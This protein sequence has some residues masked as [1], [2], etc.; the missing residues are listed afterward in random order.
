MPVADLHPT[1]GAWVR[2][3]DQ[4]DRIGRVVALHPADHPTHAD[5]DWGVGNADRISLDNLGS[6]LLPNFVV[7]DEP[8]TSARMSLGPG[9]IW[10]TRQIA[11]CDQALVHF[12]RDG[13]LLWLPYETL[14]RIKDPALEYLRAEM[15]HSDAGERWALKLMAHA[16]RTWNEATGALDRLDV[17]P[18]PHQIQLVHKILMSGHS[19]W[20][21][22]DDVGLGK[23]IEVGLLLAAL[24]RQ[25]RARRVLIITPA[26]LTRQWQTEMRTK[27]DRVY[28]IYG[29]DFF[30]DETWKW[31][32]HDRVIASLDLA[33]PRRTSDE[34]NSLDT[35]FGKL[36]AS[37][38]WDLIIF[39]EAHRLSRSDDGRQT[40]RYKLAKALRNRT[41]G[42]LLLT[43]TPHQGDTGKF[44][45]L[46]N[47]A[48]PDLHQAI[49][50]I[51]FQ[52]DIVRD[53]IVRNRK[54]DVTDLEG[55]FIFKG[56]EVRLLQ[57]ES[58]A[59]AMQLD[60]DLQKYLRASFRAAMNLDGTRARAVG[61]VMTIF[62]KLAS[63]SPA[64]LRG[65]LVRR[66]HR[67]SSATIDAAPQASRKDVEAQYGLELDTDDID[68]AVDNEAQSFFA[69][70]ALEL[71]K[72]IADCDRV[73]SD[74]WKL[75]DALALVHTITGSGEKV[76]LF[77]EYRGTQDYLTQALEGRL[78]LTV[79]QIN[80]SQSIDEKL[81]SVASFEGD[82]PV[83]ISTE[84]G[85]EG[86]NLHRNCRYLLN[87]D[88][89]WNP[90]RLVQRIGR[91]YRYGQTRTVRVFNLLSEDTIDDKVL[92]VA[93]QRVSAIVSE[94]APVDAGEFNDRLRAEILGDILDHLDLSEFLGADLD[95]DRS[96]Q[97]I[98][99]AIRRAQ[100]AR[101]LE[102]EVLKQ[103][104]QFDR[105]GFARL[106]SFTTGHL[107][108]LVR[109]AAPRIEV[110]VE[111]FENPER[112]TLRLPETLRGRFPEFAGRLVI[113]TTTSRSLS[114]SSSSLVLLD[115]QNS[116][117]RYLVSTVIAP[118]FGGGF[119]PV[120]HDILEGD[121]LVAFLCRWQNEQ[122]E[123][124]DHEVVF[125]RRNGTGEISIDP[126][127]VHSLFE[128][129]V[130]TAAL[131]LD[132]A[133]HRIDT[134][135]AMRDRIETAV[136]QSVT[137]FRHVNDLHL[138]GVGEAGPGGS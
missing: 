38:S 86:F 46:L 88:L 60:M 84:A 72:L 34:G 64:A 12:E 57:I 138:I 103:A 36:L 125:A 118:E 26:G 119:A 52:P 81:D 43:G 5:I 93:M 37:D 62:R 91:L 120:P 49:M 31:K 112:F 29:S 30:V 35:H 21:I 55:E 78:G 69:D 10:A 102:K 117:V 11:G 121:Q 109:R 123:L 17:D 82:T 96:E 1:I 50:D 114:A 59:A 20:V 101:G 14:A 33:K 54:I 133:Q 68:E 124:L 42:L 48:R 130:P 85:G 65:A 106:G 16:L 115:F 53:I 18:L 56:H 7:Q 94:M 24:E 104:S 22:A 126:T 61:F 131:R 76:I 107:A 73:L 44:R 90:A 135:E 47:L 113:E 66:R 51:E 128:A 70:E 67:L 41:D 9:R 80:G 116:F 111:M 6:G 105:E 8:L 75:R 122:A 98:E 136:A 63:S 108:A 2:Q 3:L 74:D 23:T 129:E 27:F 89:P 134:L 71:E 110:A 87:Y 95:V 97:R 4:P 79:T 92:T 132:D 83:L 28:E 19:N 13:R 127:S 25:G 45:S 137:K 39:D 100:E 40:L 32:L 99:Q 15:Q 58:S 77:T